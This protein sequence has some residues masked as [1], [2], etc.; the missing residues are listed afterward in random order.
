MRISDKKSIDNYRKF[1]KNFY[2]LT[3]N[4]A[5]AVG[6]INLCREYNVS[7]MVMMFLYKHGSI[8]K[9]DGNKYI[10]IGDA[11]TDRM[12]DKIRKSTCNYHGMMAKK[13]NLEKI[14]IAKNL[15][16]ETQVTPIVTRTRAK[17]KSFSLFW[18]L[19]KFNY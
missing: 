2:E 3:K 9:V 11:P 5:K 19:I 6:A 14:E 17:K 7:S 12:C 15:A 16:P 1:I 10:W 13:R 18:G 4:N 8:K